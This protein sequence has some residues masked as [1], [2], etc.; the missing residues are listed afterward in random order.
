MATAIASVGPYIGGALGF[1]IGP[2]VVGNIVHPD[3]HNG[4][5]TY[6]GVNTSDP[7]ASSLALAA[8]DTLFYIEAGV[9]VVTFICT[10]AY[11]PDKPKLPPSESA[12]NRE[13]ADKANDPPSGCGTMLAFFRLQRGVQA[14]RANMPRFWV[15]AIAMAIPLGV[16]QVGGGSGR[17]RGEGGCV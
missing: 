16:T 6:R 4:T 3:G 5:A 17:G 2:L 10:V 7:H 12:A 15:F 14:Q 11:F 13:L 9:V 8:I 1:V